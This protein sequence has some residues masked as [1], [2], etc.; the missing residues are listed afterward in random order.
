MLRLQVAKQKQILDPYNWE[1]LTPQP[2]IG[3]DEAGR[4]CLAGRVYAG[5]VCLKSKEGIELYTDSKLLSESRRE[6]YFNHIISHHHVG[7][8]F[9]TVQEIES[10]NILKAALLA[11]KRAVEN[12]KFSTGHVLID[13]NQKIPNLM[14]FEQTTLVKGDL[15]AAP[16]AAASII[17][18]VSRDRYMSE[19]A[20]LYPQYDFKKHKGYGTETH[21]KQIAEHG[22][23][24]EHRK[25]FSG[26][27]EYLAPTL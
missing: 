14:G 23:S 19:I 17:A 5:A 15:R 6:E 1:I 12:L 10:I 25:T 16:V 9:A 7:I 11:M 3:V 26:V 24:P 18:K 8:G 22:P 20:K 27:K 2:I 13:G 4:G 21:R